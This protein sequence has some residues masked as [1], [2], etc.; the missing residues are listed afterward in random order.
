ML[1]SDTLVGE[2][3]Y[4][5]PQLYLAMVRCQIQ[6]LLVLHDLLTFQEREAEG[7]IDTSVRE[8]HHQERHTDCDRGDLLL[9]EC[10]AVYIEVKQKESSRCLVKTKALLY[11]RGDLGIL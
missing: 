5:H 2:G 11:V 7:L 8:R 10:L 3:H 1:D 9:D 4:P 6:Y